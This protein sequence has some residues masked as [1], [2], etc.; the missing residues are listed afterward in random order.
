MSG[1]AGFVHRILLVYYML[2]IC[3]THQD[4]NIISSTLRRTD[5]VRIKFKLALSWAERLSRSEQ[6]ANDP[7]YTPTGLLTN[8]TLHEASWLT[9]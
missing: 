3:T 5:S 4:Q 2:V 6:A 1:N 7:A 9:L 8:N